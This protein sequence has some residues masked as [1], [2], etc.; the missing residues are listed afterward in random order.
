M[1]AFADNISPHFVVFC[2]SCPKHGCFVFVS[3]WIASAGS[4]SFIGH[5]EHVFC[6]QQAIPQDCTVYFRFLLAHDT[7]L[8]AKSFQVKNGGTFSHQVS[9]YVPQNKIILSAFSHSHTSKFL[10][11]FQAWAQVIILSWSNVPT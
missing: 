7:A 9:L 11:C 2:N 3:C 10:P 6:I 5:E 1:F 8:H 4:Y